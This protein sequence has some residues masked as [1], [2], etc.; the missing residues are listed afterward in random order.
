MVRIQVKP[1]VSIGMGFG[2]GRLVVHL[3]QVQNV[4]VVLGV[5]TVVQKVVAFGIMENV[6]LMLGQE[7]NVVRAILRIMMKNVVV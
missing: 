5:K 4:V 3:W 1:V 7:L 2:T 6:V